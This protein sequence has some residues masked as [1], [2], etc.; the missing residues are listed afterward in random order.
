MDHH[1]SVIYHH[2]SSLSFSDHWCVI[3]HK[4]WY[5]LIFHDYASREQVL[6]TPPH[7]IASRNLIKDGTRSS[8]RKKKGEEHLKNMFSSGIGCSARTKNTQT[9]ESRHPQTIARNIMKF[10]CCW[11][12]RRDPYDNNTTE[13]KWYNFRGSPL[14]KSWR[15]NLIFLLSPPSLKKSIIFFRNSGDANR[16]WFRLVP[17]HLSEAEKISCIVM[18]LEWEGDFRK[19]VGLGL[20]NKCLNETFQRP[21]IKVDTFYGG[22]G[23]ATWKLLGKLAQSRQSFREPNVPLVHFCH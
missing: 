3:Q 14:G 2:F 15:E 19:E 8:Q 23:G 4:N 9:E 17:T 5:V 13:Q 21:K 1:W 20:Y 18:Q 22:D 10:R 11:C 16:V 7:P 6:I 12:I